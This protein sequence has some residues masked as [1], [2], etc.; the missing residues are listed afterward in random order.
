MFIIFYDDFKN[1]FRDGNSPN[2]LN[3]ARESPLHVACRRG[4]GNTTMESRAKLEIVQL[5]WQYGA[6]INA[7]GGSRKETPLAVAVDSLMVYFLHFFR[8]I[9]YCKSPLKKLVTT[10]EF[11]NFFFIFIL[12]TVRKL[13]LNKNIYD[14]KYDRLLRWINESWIKNSNNSIIFKYLHKIKNT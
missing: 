3:R 2:A 1:D 12:K 11:W 14:D 6:K 13:N 10:R 7:K 5:L 8:F 4:Q 9:I